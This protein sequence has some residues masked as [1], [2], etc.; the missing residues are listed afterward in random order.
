MTGWTA[1]GVGSAGL[2][3]LESPRLGPSGPATHTTPHVGLQTLGR[4]WLGPP[5]AQQ[6]AVVPGSTTTFSG[7]RKECSGGRHPMEWTV[8]FCILKLQYIHDQH[9]PAHMV[10]WCE[11]ASRCL[12][13]RAAQLQA[14]WEEQ[15]SGHPC[16]QVPGS[17]RESHSSSLPC[18][19]FL[20]TVHYVVCLVR[21]PAPAKGLG[22]SVSSKL[23]G[24]APGG[25]GSQS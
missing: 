25:A 12:E 8:A 16:C 19:S 9:R 7:Q 11:C 5:E 21:L 23:H 20:V 18:G 6:G 14:C 15:G 1:A 13:S 2:P 17:R 4:L 3:N 10:G 22:L 24:F